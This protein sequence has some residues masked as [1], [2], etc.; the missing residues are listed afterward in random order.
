M[1]IA[2]SGLS[3][4]GNTTTSEI[5]ASRLGFTLV[6]FTFKNLAVE[7]GMNFDELCAL[8]KTTDEIDK[9]LDRRQ[10]EMAE[11]VPNAILASRLAIWMLK[12]ADYRVYL[13]ASSDTRATRIQK[14]EGGE[15]LEVKE[16]TAKRDESDHSRYL[17]LYGINNYDHS[18][19][20]FVV[21]TDDKSAEEVADLIYTD[22]KERFRF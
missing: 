4:C 2:I 16:K 5:L 15:F 1:K 17:K 8:A 19:A 18:I 3:G 10:V 7:K 13:K 6:N 14:R 22:I 11:N 12:D 20:D 9:E 21:D